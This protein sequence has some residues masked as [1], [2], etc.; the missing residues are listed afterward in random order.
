MLVLDTVASN[1]VL[2]L[3][4]TRRVAHGQPSHRFGNRTSNF[5]IH[6]NGQKQSPRSAGLAGERPSVGGR[7]NESLPAW[8]QQ[9]LRVPARLHGMTNFWTDE[10]L[11]DEEAHA[12]ARRKRE[13]EE[14]AR[15]A[16]EEE[17]ERRKKNLEAV[18]EN[19]CALKYILE[20][21]RKDHAIVLAAV[22]QSGQ[23]LQF[24]DDTLRA[25]AEIVLAAVTQDGV[26]LQH[27]DASLRGDYD[28][29]L[30]AVQQNGWA[31]QH[32]SDALKENT[33]IVLAAVRQHAGAIQYA[34]PSLKEDEQIILAAVGRKAF[35]E[36][37][38]T[39]SWWRN[40][41]FWDVHKE[42]GYGATRLD[43]KPVEGDEDTSE[44]AE[45]KEA[46]G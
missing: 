3:R 31:L 13:E 11:Y 42:K 20:R 22:S 25:D 21:Y 28:I 18:Q 24:A 27:A 35:K 34:G 43:G 45:G 7:A 1:S 6:K 2:L 30:A 26:A 40:D 32:A 38:D 37:L 23:T 19:G 46:E 44:A 12:I 9:T 14:L 8:Q 10:E 36:W 15:K 29:V 41:R 33:D 16:A 39:G 5:P 17:A 4:L